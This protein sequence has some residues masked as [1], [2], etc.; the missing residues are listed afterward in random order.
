[1]PKEKGEKKK[2]CQKYSKIWETDLEL[3]DWPSPDVMDDSMAYYKYCRIV[4]K[5]HKKAL[6]RHA[7][8]E[9][10]KKAIAFIAAFIAEHTAVLTVD[11]LI[12]LLP[13]ID[14]SSDALKSLRLHRTKCSM[15]IQNVLGPSLLSELVEEIGEF[16]YS[17][18]VD[19]SSDLSTQKVLCIMVRFYSSKKG[20]YSQHIKLIE[21]DA[22]TVYEF[23]KNQLIKDGLK[24]LDGAN[25]IT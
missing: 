11:H 20:K 21:C 14:S 22:K 19:E 7:L 3:K 4:L 8:T 16:P 9:K 18:I 12:E 2:Y 25:V 13:Q 1:M 23:I 10:H 6:L 24:C 5:A 17:I 15:I